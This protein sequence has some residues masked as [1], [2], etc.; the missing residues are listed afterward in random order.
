MSP[1]V[2][3]L[4]DFV[5]DLQQIERTS[6]RGEAILDVFTRHT[7]FAGGAL[8][9]SEPRDSKLRLDA[10]T[11]Q[12]VAP[13]IFDEEIPADLSTTSGQV[14]VPL[15]AGRE[16]L[17]LIKLTSGETSHSED[18]LEML[19]AA[20]VF[21]SALIANQRLVQEMREGDFQLKYRVWE[22]ESL[23]D[24]GLSIA[25]TLNI[26]ELADDV[27]FRMI[28]LLNARSAALLLRDGPTFK[29]YRSFGDV[30][31]DPDALARLSSDAA[32]LSLGGGTTVAVPIKG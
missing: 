14:L 22:L 30:N 23:Y 11:P 20:A 24:I 12:C 3:R 17:G 16:H 19:R 28:S 1:L 10:R 26:D 32:P 8:Y 29:A 4:A 15:R 18:D 5:H 31:L 21:V 9:L 25:G 2:R 27:L 13:E 6:G 7:A